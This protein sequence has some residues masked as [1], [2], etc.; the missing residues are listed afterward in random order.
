MRIVKDKTQYRKLKSKKL[1]AS[2]SWLENKN[3][4]ESKIQEES[5][6]YVESKFQVGKK[7]KEEITSS[8]R[9][10]KIMM[11]QNTKSMIISQQANR[12]LNS[13]GINFKQIYKIQLIMKK[14]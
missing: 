6:R 8:N 2:K 10:A 4:E 9:Q 5:K 13:I 12:I 14:M 1:V 7:A 3:E 11:R